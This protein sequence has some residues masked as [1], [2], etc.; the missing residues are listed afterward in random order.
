MNNIALE[1]KLASVQAGFEQC[2]WVHSDP[3]IILSF[4]EQSVCGRL[5]FE[6][7]VKQI[8]LLAQ[9]VIP[10]LEEEYRKKAKGMTQGKNL[11]YSKYDKDHT[12]ITRD[13]ALSLV[14]KEAF[15]VQ[16]CTNDVCG[17]VADVFTIAETIEQTTGPSEV[18]I[19][20]FVAKRVTVSFDLREI[21]T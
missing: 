20:P 9:F 11:V 19:E 10:K 18:N 16:N 8:P 21:P 17:Q 15:R 12:R 4:A 14:G 5:E 2:F 13:E 1:N 3:E 7:E 6:Y